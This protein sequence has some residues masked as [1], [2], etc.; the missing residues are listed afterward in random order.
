MVYE[1][2]TPGWRVDLHRRIGER[3]ERGYGPL[4]QEV[5]AELAVHFERGGDTGR[6]V[7]YL[8]QAGANASRRSAHREA[9]GLLTKGLAL[10]Q[11]L[12]DTPERSQQELSLQIALDGPLMVTKGYAAPEV[13]RALARAREL[14]RQ[15]GETPQVFPVLHG[16]W[17]FYVM[18]AEHKTARELAE[19]QLRLAQQHQPDSALLLQSHYTLG[20]SLFY[21]G[22]FAQARAYVEQGM[23]LSGPQGCDSHTFPYGWDLRVACWGLAAFALWALGYPDQALKRSQEALT[24]AQERAHPFILDVAFI[25]AAMLHRF[26]REGQAAQKLAEATMTLATEQ[27][28]PLLLAWGLLYGAE[29]WPSRDRGRRE[30]RRCSQGL[31]ARRAMRGGAV[32]AVLSRPVGRGV[33]ESRAVKGRADHTERGAGCRGRTLGSVFLRRSC[34]GSKASLRSPSLESRV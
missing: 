13:E 6:A 22:Q 30:L 3:V 10:L 1:R 19:E 9:I 20:L 21:L 5:A 14:C 24:L 33:W 29:R 32:P 16:L 23:I 18:Q 11:T 28:F 26:R 4:T 34:I 7:Q 31:A 12:P 15:L 17:A 8:G 25:F 2:V 27:G